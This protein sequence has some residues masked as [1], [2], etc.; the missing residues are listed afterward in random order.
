M[1]F[2]VVCSVVLIVAMYIG[3]VLIVV[4]S[5]VCSV[6]LLAAMYIVIG[7]DDCYVCSRRHFQRRARPP[8]R[9]RGPNLAGDQQR[10][11]HLDGCRCDESVPRSRTTLTTLVITTCL[12]CDCYVIAM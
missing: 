12:L 10:F 2:D 1:V 4:F 3:V 9:Y 5:A 6:V 8:S 11:W 7:A